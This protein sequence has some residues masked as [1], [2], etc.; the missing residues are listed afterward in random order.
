MRIAVPV[1]KGEGKHAGR[2]W[3]WSIDSHSL[4]QELLFLYFDRLRWVGSMET[5]VLVNN[6]TNTGLAIVNICFRL[7]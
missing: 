7:R 1:L 2:E 5:L 3:V 6:R 4:L